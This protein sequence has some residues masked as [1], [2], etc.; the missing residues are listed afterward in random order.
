MLNT[1]RLFINDPTQTP[2]S[3]AKDEGKTQAESFNLRSLLYMLDLR[4]RFFIVK[5]IISTR[6]PRAR[7]RRISA[8]NCRHGLSSAYAADLR[9]VHPDELCRGC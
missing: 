3:R 8:C 6:P 2:R 9:F 4:Y 7:K 1:T 5:F